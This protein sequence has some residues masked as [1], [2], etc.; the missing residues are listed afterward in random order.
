METLQRLDGFLG[1]RYPLFVLGVVL[2]GLLFPDV[3]SHLNSITV[4]LFAFTTFSSSLGGGFRDLARA[5]AHPLPVVTVLVLLHVVMPLVALGVGSVLLSQTPLFTT[6]LVLEYAIPTAVATLMWVGIGGGNVSLCLSILLLDTLLS[7][8]VIPLTMR[9]LCGSA[10]ELDAWGMMRDL[11]VMVAIPAL[12]AMTVYQLTKGRCAVTWKPRLSPVAKLCLLL[13]IMANATGCAP[14]LRELNATLAVVIL[15][16]FTLC[17][18]G[19]FLG[20]QAGRRLGLPFPTVLTMSVTGGA[21]N[22]SVGAVLAAQYFPPD[23]LFPVAFSPIFMQLTISLVVKAL[24]ATGPGRAWRK[25][26]AGTLES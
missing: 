24:L 11:L 21:R 14:F 25:E 16:V 6:G 13:V 4:P 15:V 10:V 3:F 12:A 17:L 1:R 19:F 9:L 26:N 2:L 20:Y 7:P 23:V 5:F 18:L 8:F 22:I